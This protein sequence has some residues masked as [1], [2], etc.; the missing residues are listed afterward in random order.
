M[1]DEAGVDEDRW[2]TDEDTRRMDKFDGTAREISMLASGHRNA[3]MRGTM[4]RDL[5]LS[6][7]HYRTCIGGDT[8]G[9]LL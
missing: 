7:R 1:G 8:N 5:V 2:L 4:R 3:L 6:E 9:F